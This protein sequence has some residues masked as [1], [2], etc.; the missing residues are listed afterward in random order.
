MVPVSDLKTA[1]KLRWLEPSGSEI[2]D[3]NPQ[4][5]TAN[6]NK[7]L[8]LMEHSA[9]RYRDD[10]DQQ[11]ACAINQLNTGISASPG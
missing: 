4:V 9:T 8:Q 3:N 5:R 7:L 6:Q 1:Q 2:P 10:P 11:L